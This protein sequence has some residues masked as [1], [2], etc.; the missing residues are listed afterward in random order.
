MKRFKKILSVILLSSLFL[1]TMQSAVFA[2]VLEGFGHYS[3]YFSV[4]NNLTSFSSNWGSSRNAWNNACSKVNISTGITYGEVHSIDQYVISDSY[5]GMTAML[6]NDFFITINSNKCTTANVQ[7]VIV[8]ELGHILNLNDNN[9]ILVYPVPIMSNYRNREV[10]KT[11][12][13]DDI[14]GV[15]I[16]Y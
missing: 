5:Y 6:G 7:S 15:N 9:N 1:C 12:Q 3:S 11:P 16:S 13:P 8:H 10:V 2:Y 14:A 4:E